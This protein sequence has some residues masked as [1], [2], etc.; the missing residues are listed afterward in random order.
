[1]CKHSYARDAFRLRQIT[2][3]P[4]L[5]YVRDWAPFRISW[6]GRHTLLRE[7]GPWLCDFGPWARDSGLRACGDSHCDNPI[8]QKLREIGPRVRD[9]GP[10]VRDF[11]PRVRAVKPKVLYIWPKDHDLGH[12]ARG[13]DA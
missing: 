6:A 9:F 3:A 4:L 1:M 12:L 7:L 2:F 8:E 5:R 11:G 10:R 13:P